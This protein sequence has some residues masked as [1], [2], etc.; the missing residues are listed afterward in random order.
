MTSNSP[1][2]SNFAGFIFTAGRVYNL[3]PPFTTEE[4]LQPWS[5]VRVSVKHASAVLLVVSRTSI[6]VACRA[7]QKLA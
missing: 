1:A 7:H 2:V 5:G 3:C 6:R 4:M